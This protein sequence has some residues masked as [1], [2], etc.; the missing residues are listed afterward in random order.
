MKTQ[1]KLADH[2]VLAGQKIIEIWHDGR[3]IGQVVGADGPGV[4]VITKHEIRVG[5]MK[6]D[7]A[8]LSMAEVTIG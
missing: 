4:R 3:F 2:S 1:L 8:G 5:M 6:D 7:L